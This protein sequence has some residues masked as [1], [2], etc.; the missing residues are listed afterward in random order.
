MEQL[1]I[2]ANILSAPFGVILTVK[3]IPEV[4]KTMEDCDLIFIDTTGRNSKNAMQV[5]EIRQY[6]DAL[7]PDGIHLVL[8]MTTKCKDIKRIANDYKI[9]KYTSLILTKI[10][11]TD[12][13]GSILASLYYA[14]VPVSFLTT[15]QN[16]PDDIQEAKTEK[17]FNLIMGAE[18]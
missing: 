2:Y 16:V 6:I 4:M 10:D 3:D 7:K 14:N 15:G 17:L 1:K 13:C 9:I 18:Q 5:S 11:E 8:S 12:T